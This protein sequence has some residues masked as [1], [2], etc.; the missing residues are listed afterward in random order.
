M[1][2]QLSTPREQRKVLYDV[3]KQDQLSP[4]VL[5]FVKDGRQVPEAETARQQRAVLYDEYQ[6]D[7]PSKYRLEKRE[8]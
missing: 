8:E 6:Q 3:E 5:V 4:F 1:T 2:K 7:Q